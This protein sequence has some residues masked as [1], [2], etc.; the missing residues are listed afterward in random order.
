MYPHLNGLLA[1]NRI[2]LEDK[3]ESGLVLR[4]PFKGR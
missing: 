1:V 2:N 4:L 3:F